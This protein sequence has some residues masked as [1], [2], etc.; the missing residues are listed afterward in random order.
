[1][2]FFPIQK[3]FYLY[4]PFQFHLAQNSTALLLKRICNCRTPIL[5]SR[6][7]LFVKDTRVLDTVCFPSHQLSTMININFWILSF[8]FWPHP[9]HA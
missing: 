4:I 5:H 8:F 1:M 2:T 3:Y 6:S 9:W 7:Y